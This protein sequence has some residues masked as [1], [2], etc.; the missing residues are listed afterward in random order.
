M[1][2]MNVK[3]CGAMLSVLGVGAAIAAFVAQPSTGSSAPAAG[4]MALASVRGVESAPVAAP[5][6]SP[7]AID[8]NGWQETA[9]RR[10]SIRR[11]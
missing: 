4:G 6:A 7:A 3:N 2:L 10:G 9:S 11:L 5:P 8:M 1:C